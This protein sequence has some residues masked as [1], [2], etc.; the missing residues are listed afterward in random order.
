MIVWGTSLSPFTRKVLGFLAEKKIPFEHRPVTPHADAAEFRACSPVGKIPAIDDD[1][2]RLAD[3]SAICHYLERKYPEP[4][5]FPNEVNDLGRMMWWEEF[6]DTILVP[7]AGQVFFQLN[8]RPRLRGEQPDMAVV[9]KALTTDCPRVFAH[10]EKEIS[11]PFIVGDR[12]TL[13]D[14]ALHCIFV[15]LKLAGHPLD[16]ARWPKLGGYIA[17]LMARP[18]LGGIRDPKT[19]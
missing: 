6:N 7:A 1:G 11:G 17:G 12:L 18:A 14:I 3:S 10:L 4:A 19:S 5:L 2:Y 8:V 15:N 16:A 13:A 9:D